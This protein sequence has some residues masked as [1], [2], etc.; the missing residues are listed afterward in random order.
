MQ[1]YLSVIKISLAQEFV[2][3]LNF[4]MWRVRNIIQILVFYF[5]WTAVFESQSNSIGTEVSY[6]GYTQSSI[7]AYTFLLILIRSIVM[8][9]KST[10]VSGFISNGELSNYLVKPISFFKYLLARDV[11]TK[12]LNITFSFIEIS[13]LYL[14]LKPSIFIQTN[15]YQIILFIFSLFIAGFIYFS[16]VMLSNSAPFWIPELGWG[17][18]FL[19]TVIFVEFLSGAFFPLDVFPKPLFE[20]LKLTPFPY[21]VFIPIQTYLGNMSMYETYKSLAIGLLWSVILWMLMNKVWK[22]GLKI[23]EAVGR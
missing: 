22:K 5:L 10:D 20:F 12:L 13:I 9:T 4:I 1:K 14:I 23:Y 19:V 18:Q 2:Y 7:V 16:I 17:V 8:A 6:F 11:S 3:K 15:P 21:L